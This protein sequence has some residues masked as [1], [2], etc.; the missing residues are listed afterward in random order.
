ML[1]LMLQAGVIG[2]S[3]FGGFLQQLENFGFF[4]YILP[5][6]LIFAVVYAILGEVPVFKDKKGPI[7]IISLAIGLLALQLDFVPAFFQ[8]IFPR[9]GIGLS[10]LIV[11][12]IL[13]GSFIAN[14]DDDKV[15]KAYKWIFFGLGA[16]I[17]LIVTFGSLSSNSFVG[18]Y[19]WQQYGGL[20]IIGI[21]IAGVI[22]AV[23]VG[24]KK[25]DKSGK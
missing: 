21:V 22:V 7:L 5:F 15:S 16:L 14:T 1:G 12:L 4:Q 19:W 8:T 2:S 25:G 20:I 17:F 3:S 13:A 23:A 24:G 11:A 10:V 6:L 18:S 9:F